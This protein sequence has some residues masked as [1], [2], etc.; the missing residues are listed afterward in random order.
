[1]KTTPLLGSLAA[2]LLL[3]GMSVTVAT[4]QPASVDKCYA[5]HVDSESPQA[6]KF[7]QDVHYQNGVGCADCH[8]GDPTSDDQDV[9]MSPAKGYKGKIKPAQ[10][11]ELCGRCHGAGSNAFKQRFHLSN[12]AD[13]LSAGAHGEALR[14][15][16]AGP[17]CVSCHGVHDIAKV[18]DPRS[19]VHPAHVAKTCAGC[20]SNALYMRQFNPGLP[21]DQYEKYLTSLHGKKNAAGD[22]KPATCVSCHS[23]HMIVKVKDPRS[24]VYAMRIPETCGKCHSNAKYMAQYHIPTD[25]LAKYKS[26]QHGIALL[27]KSDL[28]APACNSCHG[29]HG[30]APP[31]AASVVAVCGN[32]HQTNEELY[33]KSA[34][35]EVFAQ[36]KLSGC[37]VCHGN[38]GIKA[39]SDDLVAFLPPS[40]CAQC[41]TQD[42]S[43]KDAAA[44]VHIRGLLDSLEVGQ[45]EALARLDKAEQLGMDVADQKYELKDVHQA[46]VL[47]RVAVHSFKVSE[48]ADVARPGIAIVAAAKKSGDEAV[49]EYFFR[50][51]G[52][53]V[54]TL[55]V[56]L[57][58]VLLYLKI[59]QIDKE[60]K[61]Q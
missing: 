7:K 52:L 43:D 3:A 54:S 32:C 12:V 55:I 22:P 49:H 34:H 47:S 35:K 28:N 33:Q 36:K 2:L 27:Q 30:A 6:M 17:Q 23:N 29:N 21:V 44:I 26:S 41:H 31:G 25:Q 56:T 45:K 13:S 58:V 24:P 38:H 11:P 39:P 10:I 42:G 53:A 14:A 57:L 4:A 50:R 19:L 1:M 16:P 37:V 60:A 18:S 20:H 15:N 9:A 5:C 51:Q 46:L 40:P 61:K 8:G 48:V 59:R